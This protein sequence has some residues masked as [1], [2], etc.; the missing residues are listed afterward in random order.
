MK[1]FNIVFDEGAKK[2][3]IEILEI[4]AIVTFLVW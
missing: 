3:I 2:L 4:I 1:K